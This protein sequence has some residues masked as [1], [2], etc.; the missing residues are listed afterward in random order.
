MHT[1]YFLYGMWTMADLN[2][3]S[4][5]CLYYRR[6]GNFNGYNIVTIKVRIVKLLSVVVV[7][8]CWAIVKVRMWACTW[9]LVSQ[10]KSRNESVTHRRH[11]KKLN[12]SLYS[13]FG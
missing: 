10:K 12:Y 7:R 2:T 8:T 5:Q 1:T 11:E 4:A 9:L 3:T 13:V 6:T